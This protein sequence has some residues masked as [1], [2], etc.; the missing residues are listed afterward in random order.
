LATIA[1]ANLQARINN[2]ELAPPYPIQTWR[3]QYI[4]EVSAIADALGIAGLTST[5]QAES[6]SAE[7]ANFDVPLARILI[8]IRMRSTQ[9]LKDES[10]ALSVTSKASI[11][12]DLEKLR[13]T[14]NQSN[15]SQSLKDSLHKK[16]RC[17]RE[18]AFKNT[19][20]PA[21]D[22]DTGGRAFSL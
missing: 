21:A 10:V 5:D 14:V 19:Q 1:R 15:V 22:M 9:P 16:N 12:S 11:A 18:R 2:P 6:S 3:S 17:G 8:R 4:H 7:M 20:Q 13:E